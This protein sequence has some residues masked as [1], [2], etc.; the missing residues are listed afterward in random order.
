MTKFICSEAQKQNK[1]NCNIKYSVYT[2]F[3]ILSL[4]AVLLDTLLTYDIV[5]QTDRQ[6][7]LHTGLDN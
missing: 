7:K 5:L 1:H 6:S 4:K 2:S 3:M